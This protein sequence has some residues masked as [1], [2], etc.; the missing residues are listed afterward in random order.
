MFDAIGIIRG[1]HRGLAAVL[2]CLDGALREVERGA[3]E[4]D[5]ELFRL[6]LSY[7]DS[8]L[9]RYHHPK[10]DEYLFRRLRARDPDAAALLDDLEHEHEHV[11]P[12]LTKLKDA[13][14]AYEREGASRLADFRAAVDR[15]NAFEWEHMRKEEEEIIPLAREK[16]ADEDWAEIDDAFLA[17]DDPLFG[18]KPREEFR[19]L[20]SNIVRLAP[21]PHGYGMGTKPE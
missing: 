16:L 7:I 10:E 19:K 12:E 3:Q 5:F 13:L 17:N 18:D 1:E 14:D 8:F 11:G 15:Y 9:D 6:I 21:P 20:F 2:S 4:P